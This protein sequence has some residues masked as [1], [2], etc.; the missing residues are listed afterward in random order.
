[1]SNPEKI[2]KWLKILLYLFTIH[3]FTAGVLLIILPS[4]SLM[5]FGFETIN[6]FFTTQSG[7]F[8]IVMAVCYLLSALKLNEA[9]LMIHFIIIAKSLAAIFLLTY[10]FFVTHILF[11]LIFGFGDLAMAIILFMIYSLFKKENHHQ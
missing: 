10:Y 4:E 9:S 11:V 8:H 5:Y 7:V 2:G 6:R 3:S 1:M